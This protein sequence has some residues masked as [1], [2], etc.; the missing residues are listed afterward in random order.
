VDIR[1][2]KRGNRLGR[3]SFKDAVRAPFLKVFLGHLNSN[4]HPS[5]QLRT[6][7]T[8]RTV[9]PQKARGP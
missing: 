5:I 2:G 8:Q 3:P 4:I 1:G 6:D 7:L 9:G